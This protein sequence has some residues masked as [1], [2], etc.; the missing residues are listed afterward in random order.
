MTKIVLFDGECNVCNK[1]VQFIIKRDPKNLFRFASLQS[2]AGK[3]LLQTYDA[4]TDLSSIVFIE[5][6]R[7]YVK[8]TAALR[9]CRHLHGLWKFASLLLV[10]PKPIRNVCYNIIAKN[11]HKLLRANKNYCMI[12]TLEERERFL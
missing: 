9:I 8:S 3:H 4:P 11:R 1:S 12:P 10:I 6:D 2:D 5:N 7:Y